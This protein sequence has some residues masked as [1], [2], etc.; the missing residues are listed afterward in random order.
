M[1]ILSCTIINVELQ[2][3]LKRLCGPVSFLHIVSMIA[4][5][6]GLSR[7]SII[8]TLCELD[9]AVVIIPTLRK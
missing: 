5:K 7:L 3:D 2:L 9:K 6:V 8:E 4:Y 1:W